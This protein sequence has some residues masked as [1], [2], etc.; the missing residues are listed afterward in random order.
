MF[1]HVAAVAVAGLFLRYH[2]SK[3]FFYHNLKR[4]NRYLYYFST[5]RHD[6]PSTNSGFESH[7]DTN[8]HES[9]GT[10]VTA[11]ITSLSTTTKYP[12]VPSLAWVMLSS[13]E[14]TGCLEK[15][16]Q[17]LQRML[18]FT[19]KISAWNDII[20]ITMK[21]PQNIKKR[22]QQPHRRKGSI[23]TVNTNEEISSL[24][25]GQINVGKGK[26]YNKTLPAPPFLFPHRPPKILPPS[27]VSILLRKLR[28][29]IK[30]KA[31]R[32]PSN[33]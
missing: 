25:N 3:H 26:H 18:N 14:H 1:N 22:I 9:S 10:L 13:I 17:A 30:S 23:N 31:V 32:R 21:P 11:T 7:R 12:I 16:H 33:S 20:V 5:S 8:L 24:T 4:E 6:L 19:G 28:K 2:C 15:T 29:P 27:H